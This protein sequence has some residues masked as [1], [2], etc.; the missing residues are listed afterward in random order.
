MQTDLLVILEVK[1]KDI[2]RQAEVLN[3]TLN[4]EISELKRRDT[5][6]EKLLH[7]EDHLHLLQASILVCSENT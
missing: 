3:K 6:L 2:D 1:R 5:E 7:C 4:A